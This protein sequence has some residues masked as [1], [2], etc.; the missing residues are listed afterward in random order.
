MRISARCDYACRALLELALNWPNKESLTIH[1]ISEKQ[2]IPTK[3]LVHILI[4]LKRMGLVE[5]LR[6]KQGGYRLVKSPNRISLGEVIREVGGPL[7]PVANSVTRDESVFSTIWREVEGAM[8]KVL[9]GITFEDISNKEKG[10]KGAIVY[11][12]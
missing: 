2:G 12:I 9:D 5:S 1:T 11:Q 8:A 10:M 7:L 3:Y 6:G 4:Q